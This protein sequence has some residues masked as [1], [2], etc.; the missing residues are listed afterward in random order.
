M[1]PSRGFTLFEL[2]IAIFIFSIV[3]SSVYGVY[4]ATFKTID[5]SEQ[6]IETA[7][8]ARMVLE[9]ITEDLESL[10]FGTGGYLR[11]EEHELAGRR[12]DTI[13]FVSAAHLMLSKDDIFRGNGLI[14]YVVER[15]DETGM[16]QLFRSDTSILPGGDADESPAKRYLLC[17]GLADFKLS[18]TDVEGNEVNEW[19]TSE[20]EFSPAEPPQKEPEMPAL[21]SI[22][23]RLGDITEGDEVHLSVF[24]TAVAPLVVREK[25]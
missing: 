7:H 14:Q 11:G 10:V 18:Y 4:R 21:I 6:A 2:L 23:L 22:E 3:I 20:E 15:D 19:A 16:L 25:S 5:G 8:T 9:R 17:G 12:A 13:S 24:K 1:K